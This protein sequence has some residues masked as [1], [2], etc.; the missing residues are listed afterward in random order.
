[1]LL[2]LLNLLKDQLVVCMLQFSLSLLR[3]LGGNY[4]TMGT[5]RMMGGV[6]EFGRLRKRSVNKLTICHI[7]C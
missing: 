2:V 3:V 5:S 7:D 6:Y 4:E 1:M